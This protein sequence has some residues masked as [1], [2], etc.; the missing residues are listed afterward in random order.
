MAQHHYLMLGLSTLLSAI[1]MY[2]SMYAMIDTLQSFF[3][4]INQAYMAIMMAAPMVPIMILTMRSMYSHARL[5]AI[6]H[7]GSA[8]VFLLAFAAIRY[9]TAVGDRQFLRSMIPHH[10]GA[11]LMCQEAKLSDPQ[12]KRLCGQIIKSQQ[13]E[14]AQMR[15]LLDKR[16]ENTVE[17]AR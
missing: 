14:I 7:V 2:F 16:N 6:L 5:N 3:G 11:I 15:S 17:R 9:Q 1:V 13:E 8:I 4:N 10:S 12:I